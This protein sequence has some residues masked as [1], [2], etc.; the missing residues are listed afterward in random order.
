MS[1]ETISM[2]EWVEAIQDVATL[3]KALR[4]TSNPQKQHLLFTARQEAV[5]RALAIRFLTGATTDRIETILETEP[6]A[7]AFYDDLSKET[8]DDLARP[9]SR[10]EDHDG[11]T[12]DPGKLSSWYSGASPFGKS[13]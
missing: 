10:G 3:E 4:E 6:W 12:D 8:Q 13:R 11:S 2:Q 9:H 5:E 7:S 1:E